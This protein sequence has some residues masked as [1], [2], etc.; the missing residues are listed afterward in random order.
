MTTR[1][2]IEARRVLAEAEIVAVCDEADDWNEAHPDEAPIVV[3]VTVPAR[4]A[5]KERV[6]LLGQKEGDET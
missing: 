2:E 4:D 3:G 1:E 6:F 5:T